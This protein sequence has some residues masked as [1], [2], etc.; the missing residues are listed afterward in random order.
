MSSSNNNVASL[1]P[2]LNGTN[3]QQW[4]TAMKAFLLSQGLW[5]QVQG[6][7]EREELPKDKKEVAALSTEEK[8]RITAAIAQWDHDDG[9]AMGHIAL[10][11]APHI[12]ASCI[13]CVTSFSMWHALAENY[14][15]PSPASV[16]K[17]FKD[18][19]NMRIRADQDPA[20]YFDKAYAAYSRMADAQVNVPTQLQAMIALAALPQKWDM[21]V[22]IVSGDVSLEDLALSNV[23]NAVIAQYQSDSMRHGSGKQTAN[24]ISAVKRKHGNPNFN[25]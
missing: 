9:M 11:V 7:V 23:R 10:R 21:L 19:I 13:N 18:T 4:A 6:N 3:Y 5:A 16:F 12:Q 2:V 25:Q 24:K 1:V 22:S 8:K 15:K 20:S 17:D 14:G